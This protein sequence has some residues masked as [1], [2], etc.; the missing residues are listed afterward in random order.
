MYVRE[1]SGLAG[2]DGLGFGWKS[3]THAVRNV[4]RP[5]T[6]IIKKYDPIL[7]TYRAQQRNK[8]KLAK[9]GKVAAIATAAYFTGGAALSLIQAYGV[10]A[11]PL[12]KKYGPTVAARL[13]GQ[14]GAPMPDQSAQ[15]MP[16]ASAYAQPVQQMPPQYAPSYS[17]PP[18]P[19]AYGDGYGQDVQQQSAP[20]P[21]ES[22]SMAKKALPWIAAAG[23][24]LALMN[25]R[26]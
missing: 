16:D 19:S 2:V 6:K 17:P 22:P 14:P 23:G 24:V 18:P 26:S 21:T 10:Y 13:L 20:A 9:V 3:V 11:L 1:E 25:N 4:V 12:I 15:A 8:H 5:V 7:L